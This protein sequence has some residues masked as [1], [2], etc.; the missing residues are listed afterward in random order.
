MKKK[1]VACFLTVMLIAFSASAQEPRLVE[2]FNIE[3]GKVSQTIPSSTSIQKEAASYL[4]NITDIYRKVSPIP[5]EGTM[6]KIPLSPEV[7]VKNRWVN[8][9]VNEVIVVI[10]KEE[11]PFLIIFDDKNKIHLFTFKGDVKKL[12]SQLK[13]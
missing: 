12:L 13:K 1:L 9:K 10:G 4:A 6:V 11:E 7:Q 8:T 3:Q 5:K 2:V